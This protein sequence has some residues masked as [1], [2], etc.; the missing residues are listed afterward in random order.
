MADIDVTGIYDEVAISED[1][2]F[3]NDPLINTYDTISVAETKIATVMLHWSVDT[4]IAF[5]WKLTASFTSTFQGSSRLPAWD[6]SSVSTEDPDIKVSRFALVLREERIGLRELSASLSVAIQYTGDSTIPV[7]SLSGASGSQMESHSPFWELSST[8]FEAG[9][10][11]LD[12]R[13]SL[14]RL[15]ASFYEEPTMQLNTYSILVEHLNKIPLL[16]GPKI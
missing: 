2:D 10:F 14:R 9:I 1:I 4:T 5:P 13:L 16:I 7:R 6:L 12:D 8:L 11:S 3:A 15:A